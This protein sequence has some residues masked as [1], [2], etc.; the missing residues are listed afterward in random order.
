MN[1]GYKCKDCPNCPYYE[2]VTSYGTEEIRCG[3][4]DCVHYGT[5]YMEVNADAETQDKMQVEGGENEWQ[6]KSLSMYP[7]RK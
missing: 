3:N 6:I 7:A 5:E 4:Y 1:E 2:R